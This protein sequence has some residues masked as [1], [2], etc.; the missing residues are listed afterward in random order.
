[1]IAHAGE[2]G[3]ITVATNMAGRGTDIRLSPD[4]A[5]LGG[6]HVIATERHEARRIDR[7]LFGRCGRQ[8]EPG[9]YES[10]V[11]LEDELVS[12]FLPALLW[13]ILKS[14][15]STVIKIFGKWCSLFIWLAQWT[16]QRRHKELRRQ[17]LKSEV[18]LDNSLAFTGKRE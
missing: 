13:Q 6:L 18:V 11:S 17:L 9:S 14:R 2:S 1:M 12:M 7:Q 15:R 3:R 4:I 8:G 16:A 5:E 10:I